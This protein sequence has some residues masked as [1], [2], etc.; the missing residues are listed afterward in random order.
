MFH[1]RKFGDPVVGKIRLMT[2]ALGEEAALPIL[3]VLW[4]GQ[5]GGAERSVYQLV[6]EQLRDPALAPAVL[7]GQP[8]GPYYELMRDL[9][10]PVLSP[11]FRT[12]RDVTRLR[13]AVRE[14]RAFKVHHFHVAEP[15]MMLASTLC[16]GTH[17]LYTHRSG[18]VSYALTRRMRYLLAG[19]LV[20]GWFNN[21]SANTA[22]AA[23]CASRFLKTDAAQIAV[24][25]NGMDFDALEP[26]R[27]AEDV[28]SELVLTPDHFILGTAATLVPS[29]RLDLL[30][31]ALV[32]PS[33]RLVVLGDGP[34]LPRLEREANRLQV[35]GQVIFTGVKSHVGDYLQVMDAFCLPSVESFGNAAV[36]A[37]AVGVPTIVFADGGGMLEHI[38]PRVTG[39]VVASPQELEATLRRLDDE[40]LLARAI[41]SRARAAVRERYA[42]ERAAPV[43]RQ[44]YRL[45]MNAMSCNR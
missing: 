18:T 30:F 23:T 3:H 29:K 11:S 10:C 43:Y 19:L 14:M 32:N 9:G 36:E 4:K 40:P 28:M 17:R 39:F 12:G 27:A 16:P 5:T 8:A 33:A 34:D 22:H 38:E 45:D 31:P 20:R 37:M 15:L 35:R 24:A 1:D 44:L 13:Q 6:G 7:F 26:R 2:T 21:V 41:G 25:Y 42:M